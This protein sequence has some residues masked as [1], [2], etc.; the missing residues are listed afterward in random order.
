MRPGLGPTSTPPCSRHRL[1]SGRSCSQWTCS[2]GEHE[3]SLVTKG[4]SGQ[5]QPRPPCSMFT[6]AA[7]NLGHV[8]WIRRNAASPLPRSRVLVAQQAADEDTITSCCFAPA[9]NNCAQVVHVAGQPLHNIAHIHTCAQDK[10]IVCLKV[11]MHL[12]VKSKRTQPIAQRLPVVAGDT[13][14]VGCS[15]LAGLS[16]QQMRLPSHGLVQRK[17]WQWQRPAHCLRR[18]RAVHASTSG[19][20]TRLAATAHMLIQWH[21]DTS[22][23]CHSPTALALAVASTRLPGPGWTGCTGP[24]AMWGTY[25]ALRGTYGVL[26]GTYGALCGTYGVLGW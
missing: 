20:P 10:H 18:H 9:N 15:G 2:C 23:G 14:A 24:G 21:A 6:A 7:I 1:P 3:C 16:P 19:R 5:Q 4:K 17:R 26:C 8:G 25:G 22:I 13:A 11:C 12:P